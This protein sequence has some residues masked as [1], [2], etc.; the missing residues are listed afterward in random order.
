MSNVES[1]L[2]ARALERLEYL[3]ALESPSGDVAH[4]DALR[5]ALATK[6]RDLGLDVTITPGPAGDHLVAQWTVDQS[7][8]H[9]LLVTHYDTVWSIGELERQPFAINGDV[10][11]GPG[12][13]DMKSGIVAIELALEELRASGRD[14]TRTVRIVCIADEEV[15]SIDGRRVIEEAAQGAVGVLG[16]EPSH[17]NGDFKS[18]RRGVARLLLR[19]TGRASHSGLA[20]ADGISAIDELVDLLLDVRHAAPPFEDAAINIGRISGGTRANVVAGAAEA[21]VGLRFSEPSSEQALLEL[22]DDLR[23]H[24]EGASLEVV[25]VSHRPAWPEDPDSW[26][27]KLVVDTA[28]AQGDEVSARPAGGAGD[29]NFTGSKGLATLD[30]LGPR[31]DHPHAVGEYVLLS[32]LLSRVQLL[33][34]LFTSDFNLTQ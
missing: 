26:L 33:V 24:R 29:T 4:L 18:G 2:A 21:E 14:P 31:G 5:D 22:F 10:V 19:V 27:T 9:L 16:M 30:G 20:A 28:R 7:D 11:T 23:V 25:T 12:V 1:D 3:T 34:S 8:G 13:L 15:S 6:W 17:P 32:S